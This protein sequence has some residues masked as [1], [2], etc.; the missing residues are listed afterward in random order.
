MPTL[1]RNRAGYFKGLTHHD[2]FSVPKIFQAW[3]IGIGANAS[4]RNFEALSLYGSHTYL[5]GE[6]LMDGLVWDIGQIKLFR[7]R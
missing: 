4:P 7:N 6:N 3:S 2:E 1:S 5:D